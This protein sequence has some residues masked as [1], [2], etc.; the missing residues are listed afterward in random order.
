[1]QVP[2]ALHAYHRVIRVVRPAL[3]TKHSSP[4]EE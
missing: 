3:G 4:P 2:A 1:L